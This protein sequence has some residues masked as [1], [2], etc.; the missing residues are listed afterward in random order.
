MTR[1]IP[2]ALLTALSQPEVQPYHAIELLFDSAPIRLWTGYGDKVISSNTYTG[3]GSLLTISGF[4]EV[5]DLSAKSIQISLSGMPST[6]VT[7]ALSEPYQRRECKVYFGTRDTATPIEVFSG[8]MN[9]MS[10]EDN[11]D[12]STISLKVE[13][14][15]IRLE[16]ASNRRYTEEN[17][18]ARHS[19][20]A[21]FSFVTK[22]QDKRVEWNGNA[23][24]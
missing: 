2:S 5:G 18:A 8:S 16:K 23:A 24:E 15:L 22:L 3:G 11:G 14:K 13:S 10:I 7:L 1:T 9:T 20:D 21:F 19:G 12:S 4:E 17:H 6:L